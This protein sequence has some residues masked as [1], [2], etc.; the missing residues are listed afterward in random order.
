MGEVIVGDGAG[1][2]GGKGICQAASDKADILVAINREP[3]ARS[4][5]SDV[6]GLRERIVKVK[7]NSVAE[8]LPQA[9]LQGV[10]GRAAD[11]APSIR[12]ECLIAQELTGLFEPRRQARQLAWRAIEEIGCERAAVVP[13][14]T[15]RVNIGQSDTLGADDR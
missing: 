10:V 4:R 1:Q 11:G 7:L 13:Q 15:I 5:G 8:L 12:G 9:R 3:N 2:V 14:P 6:L